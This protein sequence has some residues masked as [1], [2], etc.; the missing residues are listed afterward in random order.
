MREDRTRWAHWDA[1]AQTAPVAA[2][3]SVGRMQNAAMCLRDLQHGKDLLEVRLVEA[4][5]RLEAPNE[6]YLD[7]RSQV[8][9]MEEG[10]LR[11]A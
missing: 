1:Q 6:D 10:A 8:P 4:E 9:M 3:V 7:R 2:S 5:S 11:M